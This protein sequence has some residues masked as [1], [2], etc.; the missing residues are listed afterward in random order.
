M[1]TAVVAVLFL[2]ALA[3]V[4]E[5]PLGGLVSADARAIEVE[6]R[7][8]ELFGLPLLS[9]VAVVQRDRDG[10]AAAELARAGGR[11]LRIDRREDPL[12]ATVV[13]ALP[14]TNSELVFR[15]ARESGTTAITFLY[16]EPSASLNARTALAHTYA[17]R[18]ERDGDAL[19]GVTGAVPAR[20]AQW[21]EIEAAL[22]LV[23]VA[24]VTLIALVVG[25]TFR[26]PGA[27]LV[28]LAASALAF[29]IANRIVAF[30]G[31]HLGVAVPREVE[32]VMVV[33]LLGIVTDYSVFF[34]AGVRR[35]LAE[36][37]SALSAT[38][39]ASR[40]TVP[41]VAT[42]GIIVTLGTTALLV[43]RL[44]F[45]RA[46]GP[47]AAATALVALVVS[48]TFVPAVLATL[49]RIVFWPSGRATAVDE[50]RSR[51]RLERLTRRLTAR[52]VAFVVAFLSAGALAAAATGLARID[53]GFTLLRGLPADSEPRRAAR[54][55]AQG[56]APGILSPTEVVVEG[57][58][59]R[60]RRDELVRLQRFLELFPGVAGVIGPRELPADVPL[61][62]FVTADGRAARF[63][64]V[65]DEDPLAAGGI[66]RVRQLRRA[67]PRLLD[68]VELE[69]ARAALAGDTVL[70]ADTVRGVIEDVGRIAVAAL[71]VNFVLLALFLRALV[72]PLYLLAAS[73][74]ALAASLGLTT[75]VF[76]T[77]LGHEDVTYYVPFAAAVLLLSLGSDYNLF[78]V[79]RIW[80]EAARLPLR[81][82]ITIA[83]PRASGA[84]TVAGVALAGSFAL[85]ALVPLRPFRE[86][87]FVMAVGVLLDSFV[88]RTLLVPALISLVG[89]ASW[90]P[91]RREPR[92]AS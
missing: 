89:E 92:R 9:R 30:A 44:E 25:I 33:L 3:D 55:A 73:A 5:A 67:L 69:G 11:A 57:S 75:L 52:P 80:Q 56:F 39:Q 65:L 31:Q 41:I 13:F 60:R 29:L 68:F 34:L 43:G 40:V 86:F 23:E 36:G 54:A 47:G 58:G 37:A 6:R 50:E 38:E 83:A 87:A 12:L 79:G 32:P 88:V 91:G 14:V 51:S 82:A 61:D 85:L 74:L 15:G 62:V 45:F 28:A 84:I 90:W 64:V 10:L 26:S 35:R 18:I 19:A 22:P 2:P 16:Y 72:A 4:E 81:D 78:V 53:L 24:T 21:H 27:P 49:G 66:E 76:Q 7:S 59:F 71:L 77:V 1:T 63:V 17:S 42:A 48:V 20:I 70:A 8:A 46:F